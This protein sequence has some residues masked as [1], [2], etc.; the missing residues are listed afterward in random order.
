MAGQIPAAN[1]PLAANQEL[2]AVPAFLAD[3]Q[4]T[5]GLRARVIRVPLYP[6][7]IQ[8]NDMAWFRLTGSTRP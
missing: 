2:Q 6:A 8:T 7:A 4:V 1:P 3:L 5:A